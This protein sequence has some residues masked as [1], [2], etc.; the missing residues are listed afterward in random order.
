M[1]EKN[2]GDWISTI[3]IMA[4]T[5]LSC[6]VINF[7]GHNAYYSFNEIGEPLPNF[8]VLAI[9]LSSTWIC[10]ILAA[11]CIIFIVLVKIFVPR[12]ETRN[13]INTIYF[14]F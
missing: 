9:D 4:F 2:I 3:L 7:C 10:V 12:P 1:G 6:V 14:S 11:I 5:L 8:T 13:L